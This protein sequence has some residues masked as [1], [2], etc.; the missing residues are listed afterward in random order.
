[1]QNCRYNLDKYIGRDRES[2]IDSKEKESYRLRVRDRQSEIDSKRKKV[3][4]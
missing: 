2:E 3:I 1:M 4:D